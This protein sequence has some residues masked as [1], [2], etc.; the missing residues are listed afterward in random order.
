MVNLRSGV[1]T[2]EKI[3]PLL[4]DLGLRKPGRSPTGST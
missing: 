2:V 1:A 4:P 3:T